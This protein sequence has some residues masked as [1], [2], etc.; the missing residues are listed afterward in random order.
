MAAPFRLDQTLPI[1][2]RADGRFETLGRPLENPLETQAEGGTPQEWAP[3]IDQGIAQT[4]SVSIPW[5]PA[6]KPARG[7]MKL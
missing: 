5:P 1:T 7:P 6:A 3:G 2:R 4:G